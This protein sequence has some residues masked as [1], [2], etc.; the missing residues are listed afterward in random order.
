MRI[1]MQKIQRLFIFSWLAAIVSIHADASNEIPG[2]PQSKPI[3]L[4]GGTIHTVSGETIPEGIVLFDKGVISAVGKKVQLPNDVERIDVAGKHIYP[5]F[6]DAYTQLGLVEIGSISAT[7]DSREGGSMN[8]NVQSWLAVNPDSELIPV[9]RSNGILL[10]VTVPNG[11]L[12]SGRSSLLQLDGW[13]TEQ[14]VLRKDI[15]M[16][17]RW[18]S[19][20]ASLS[21]DE[22]K[23]KTSPPRES[24]QKVLR[25][26]FDL[27]RAYQKARASDP[28]RHSIDLRLEA[29]LPVIDRQLPV[30]IA[31]DELRQIQ[32]AV[33]FAIEQKIRII[34]YGGY[35]A[36]ECAPLLIEHQIPVIV[37]GTYRLPM[38]DSDPYDSAYTLPD[39]LRKLGV[40]YCIAS[41][42]KFAG[43]SVRNLPYHAA[44]ASAFGLPIDDAVKSITL[45]PAQILGVADR[46]GSIEVGKDATLFICTGDPLDVASSVESAY[47]QGRRV[48]LNDRQKRLKQ[49]YEQKYQSQP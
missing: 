6:L 49:K 16:H 34:I 28:E 37:S 29:M 48:D 26:F 47:I 39:R 7:Q 8:P 5:S 43:T 14:L 27:S 13:T 20:R 24:T 38:R 10:A 19:E 33:G 25:D 1:A 30:V 2:P 40:T 17:L 31:A 45:Y 4:F 11:G 42:G 23:A 32:S 35:D 18:P 22:K 41:Q 36:A 3:V 15:A 9:T 46:V 21:D 12:I 44:N